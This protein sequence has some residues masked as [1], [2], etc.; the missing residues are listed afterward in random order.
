MYMTI[1]T[2]VMMMMLLLLTL[3]SHNVDNGNSTFLKG[4]PLTQPT[5]ASK[6]HLGLD[7]TVKAYVYIFINMMIGK[8][9]LIF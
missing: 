2:M 6:R 9:N 3:M 5:P 7:A 4:S 1:K 8:D